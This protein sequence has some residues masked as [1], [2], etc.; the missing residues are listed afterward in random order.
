M[1]DKK[2]LQLVI[3][4]VDGPVYEGEVEYVT[5]PGIAGIMTILAHHEP[6]ISPLSV[7]SIIFK[8]LGST[9]VETY[10]IESGILEVSNNQAT[11]LV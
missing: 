3:T 11:V 2:A 1:A 4:K 9:G 6:L 8:K 7:G 5:I 10:A